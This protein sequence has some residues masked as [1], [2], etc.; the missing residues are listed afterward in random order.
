[1]A[2]NGPKKNAFE[3]TK[4]THE[5]MTEA[6]NNKPEV[7]Q[8]TQPPVVTYSMPTKTPIQKEKVK[9]FTFT[10]KPSNRKAL[11]RIARRHGFSS[12]SAFLDEWI[13]SNKDA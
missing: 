9:P 4:Q 11:N 5:K 13:E 3:N 6:L 12:T 2:F 8:I 1:M 10:L 7:E